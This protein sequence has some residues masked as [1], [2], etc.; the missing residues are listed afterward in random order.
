MSALPYMPLYVADYLADA[1]H[2]ST[3]EHGAYLLL[4]MTYWQR[5]KALPADDKKLAR[6]ARVTDAEWADIRP[7]IVEFFH[8]SADEWRHKRIDAELTAVE[9]KSNKARAAGQASANA[10]SSKTQHPPNERSTTV[11]QTLNHTDTDTY[12]NRTLSV[13]SVPSSLRSEET[14]QPRPKRAKRLR[15]KIEYSEKFERVW[16]GYLTDP[17]MSKAKAAEAF[18]RLSEADQDLVLASCPAFRKYCASNDWY[19]PVHLVRYITERRFEQHHPLGP[20]GENTMP[21]SATSRIYLPLV[22]RYRQEKGHDPPGDGTK[23]NFPTPWVLAAEAA[24]KEIHE[25]V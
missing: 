17:N 15:T 21:V 24:M 7:A 23:A 5:G 12:Q 14:D 18:E 2:L 19:R 4:I 3:L 11:Q 10:R 20:T 1:A 9:Q 22:S 16:A 6:I 25:T 13:E 8:V